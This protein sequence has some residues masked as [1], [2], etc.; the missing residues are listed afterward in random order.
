MDILKIKMSTLEVVVLI[1]FVLYIV[2]PM[3][4][5]LLLANMVNNSFGMLFVIVLTIYL[6]LYT[7][8]VIGVLSLLVAYLFMSRSCNKGKK[9]VTF[10]EPTESKKQKVM[11]SINPPKTTSLEEEVVSKMAPIKHTTTFLATT[12]KPVNENTHS[13]L[14]LK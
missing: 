12:Y 5:P 6:L 2:L 4:T 10:E 14:V 8:P 13:A 3:K 1:V 7:H 9:T 11:E